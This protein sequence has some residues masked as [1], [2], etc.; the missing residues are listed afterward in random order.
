VKF[1]QAAELIHD[2]GGIVSVHAGRKSNSLE[3]IGNKYPYKQEF[4]TD[5]VKSHIDLFD[6]GN[7]EDANDYHGIVFPS[8][9]FEDQSS[10]AQTT[11]TSQ[12]TSLNPPAG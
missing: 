10:F 6:I 3:N 4:K 12:I 2:L 5:L 1:E 7:L 9:G 8:I 11:T